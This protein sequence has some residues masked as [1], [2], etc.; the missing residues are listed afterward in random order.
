[1]RHNFLGG[2]GSRRCDFLYSHS[3]LLVVKLHFEHCKRLWQRR[4]SNFNCAKGPIGCRG[5]PKPPAPVPCTGA[6]VVLIQTPHAGRQQKVVKRDY[7]Q[8]AGGTAHSQLDAD[9]N[10]PAIRMFFFLTRS[11]NTPPNNETLNMGSALPSP[12]A[13]SMTALPIWPIGPVRFR[14][15]CGLDCPSKNFFHL[16]SDFPDGFSAAPVR[17]KKIEK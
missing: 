4:H 12:T 2:I 10:W 13:P 15:W 17:R 8:Q 7:P 9:A 5:W 1:M 16:R 14:A 11:A 6:G 3:S